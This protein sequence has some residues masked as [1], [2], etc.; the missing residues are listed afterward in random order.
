M[1][2]D[3][4]KLLERAPLPRAP[5]LSGQKFGLVALIAFG[6]LLV[7][8]FI[9]LSARQRVRQ[10]PL[11]PPKP[12]VYEISGTPEPDVALKLQ[13]SYAG[14]NREPPPLPKATTLP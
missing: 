14:W 9:T 13:K 12:G 8:L 5:R 7:Y 3:T 6:L 4:E 2:E 11:A 10:T 1:A